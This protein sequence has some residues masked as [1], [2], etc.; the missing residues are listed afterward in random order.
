MFRNKRKISRGFSLIEIILAIAIFATVS[1]SAVGIVLQG[2]ELNR[3]SA[4]ETIANQYASEGLEAVKSIK[5]QSFSLLLDNNSVGLSNSS[6]LWSFSGTQNV[7]DNR[8]SRTISI[9]SVQRDANGDVVE[10]GGTV[11]PETKKATATV[12]WT[13]SG[14]RHDSVL[15]STYLTNWTAAIVPP[16]TSKQG[17]LVYG[18]GGTSSDSYVY[19]TYD[20][21]GGVW[22]APVSMP[23]I[24]ANTNNKALRMVKVYSSTKAGLVV[25]GAGDSSYNGTYLEAGIYNGKL[26]YQKDDFSSHY[27]EWTNAG[28]AYTW[29]MNAGLSTPMMTP[30]YMAGSSSLPGNTWSN[31]SGALPIP[32]V[33]MGSSAVGKKEKMILSRHSDG[34]NQYIYAQVYDTNTASFIGS[35]KLISTITNNSSLFQQNFDGTFLANGD[36]VAIFTDNSN[37]PKFQVWNG[38]T[39][40]SVIPL[41]SVGGIPNWIVVKARP[42]TNEIMTAFFT[43]N[44]D[45]NTQYFNG[46]AYDTSS[47]NLH[48]QHSNNAPSNSHQLV[49]FAWSPNAPTKGALIYAD[50]G[51]DR[52]IT[53]KIWTADG[54]GS[55]SWSAAVNSANQATNHYLADMRIVGAPS[56]D[57][58]LACDEDNF[59]SSNPYI[60]C[61]TLNSSTPAFTTPANSLITNAS[62]TGRQRAYDIAFP[63]LSGA[64][65]I[66][67]YSDATKMPKLKKWTAG[68]NS[69]DSATTSAGPLNVIFKAVTLRNDPLSNDIM[70]LMADGNRTLYTEVW[71]GNN[72]QFY[73]T[74]SWKTLVNQGAPGSSN[75]E[76]WFDFAWD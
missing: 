3:L 7:F 4:E 64:T 5:S 73:P 39:W 46:G 30:V 65:G 51:T 56:S 32:T 53:A 38:S 35:P 36:F 13:V 20:P 43:Q 18:T 23:D 50:S 9:T 67:V 15:L 40:G 14:T 19:R 10:N 60:Y 6:G 28:G 75:D 42:G 49:D 66:N 76:Y 17:F 22:N 61:F 1:T 33:S 47:W 21:V 54:S 26:Y 48:S 70:V 24:D 37:T 68:S 52:S 58:F 27:I 29:M 31:G 59:L 11:D 41:R 55:G 34:T 63:S 2:L 72:N 71:N 44:S 16:S 45:T 25:S 62:D 74:P 57:Q 8:F 12:S 69:W